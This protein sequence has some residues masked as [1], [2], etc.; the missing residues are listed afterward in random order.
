MKCMPLTFAFRGFGA[1][2]IK[3]YAPLTVVSIK[4]YQE[5]IELANQCNFLYTELK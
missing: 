3:Y 1:K 4:L 5:Y 2:V